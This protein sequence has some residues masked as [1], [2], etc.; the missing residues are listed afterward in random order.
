MEGVGVLG[1]I[2]RLCLYEVLVSLRELQVE[3]AEEDTYR[4]T[5]PMA[6]SQLLWKEDDSSN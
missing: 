5:H 2:T 3:G 6:I 4:I 1:A